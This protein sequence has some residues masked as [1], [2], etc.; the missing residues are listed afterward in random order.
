MG[1]WTKRILLITA[2]AFLA[3]QFLP[4]N[5]S[6]PPVD[7]ARTLYASHP[8]PSEIHALFDRSCRDCHSNDT[9]W[10]WYSRV[11]PVSWI[12]ANDVH[13]G[14][15]HFNL[16]EWGTYPD[17][18]KVRK[19]GEICEQVKTEEMPDDKYTLLHHSAR[20]TA[21]E[22][23]MVCEWVDAARKPAQTQLS[24]PA[25]PNANDPPKDMR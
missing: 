19:L 5:R 16:S 4:I 9:T 24:R 17:D 22:R 20:L 2:I 13:N 18:K 8:V 12:V 3:A 10:P 21:Q 23:T 15:R 6:N 14:R 1:L 25:A 7:P 11:A